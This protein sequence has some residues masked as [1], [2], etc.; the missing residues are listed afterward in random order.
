MEKIPCGGFYLGNEFVIEKNEDGKEV[1]K[2]DSSKVENSSSFIDLTKYDTS[3][4]TFTLSD[5][6]FEILKEAVDNAHNLFGKVNLYSGDTVTA[7]TLTSFTVGD[8][9]ASYTVLSAPLLIPV[10]SGSPYGIFNLLV[11][12]ETKLVTVGQMKVIS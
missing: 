3:G 6:D 10:D 7:T 5:D 2:V 1:M 4:S 8:V 11:T 12:K 9:G